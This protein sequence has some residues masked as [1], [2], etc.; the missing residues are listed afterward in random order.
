MKN[1]ITID[2][3]DQTLGRLA[4]KIAK[5]L[6]GKTTTAYVPN[7]VKGCV[8][9]VSNIAKMKFTGKKLAQKDYYRHSG[10]PGGIKEIKLEK[11]MILDPKK[12]LRHAVS[13][14]LPKNKLQREMLNNLKIIS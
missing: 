3:T 5:L 2:A 8:I 14:M 1:I 11:Q 7:A 13:G 4:G 9:E 6:M 10:Y 12:V